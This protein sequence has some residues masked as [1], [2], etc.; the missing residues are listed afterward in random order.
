MWGV[1]AD[2][3]GKTSMAHGYSMVFAGA[4]FFYIFSIAATY[5]LLGRKERAK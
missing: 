5:I 2:I 4:G 1:V 3:F